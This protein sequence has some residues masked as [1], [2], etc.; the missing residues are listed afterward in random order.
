[1]PWHHYTG[2]CSGVPKDRTANVN[3][4]SFDPANPVDASPV[5]GD[6]W[7]AFVTR[8]TG[9]DA[10][11]QFRI[12]GSIRPSVALVRYTGALPNASFAGCP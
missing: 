1:M 10:T 2:S 5:R 8:G 7:G 11:I 4:T 3:F 9:A 6:G 12:T